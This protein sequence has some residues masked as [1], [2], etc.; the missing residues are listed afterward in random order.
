MAMDETG[1]VALVGAGP[2]DPELLTL[3]AL[4]AI[5]RADVVVHDRLVSDAILAL[6]LARRPGSTLAR[7]PAGIR[8]RRRRSAGS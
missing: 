2:G 4:R 1:S 5:E 3:K 7:R 6:I 8:C